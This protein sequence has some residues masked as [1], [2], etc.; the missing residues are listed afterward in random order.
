MGKLSERITGMLSKVTELK[1]ARDASDVLVKELEK[2]KRALPASA[3]AAIDAYGKKK[4][5]SPHKG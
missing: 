5:Q 1:L 3:K 4:N 2:D